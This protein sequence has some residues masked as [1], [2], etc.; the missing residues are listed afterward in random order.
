MYIEG[1]FVREVKVVDQQ[2]DIMFLSI[3][4]TKRKNKT[5][6]ASIVYD[7]QKPNSIKKSVENAK[8]WRELWSTYHAARPL[9][10]NLP[11]M[12]FEFELYGISQVFIF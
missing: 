8:V 4:F 10:W 2:L 7:F 3:L 1:K 11:M 9:S 6:K 12:Q 5:F